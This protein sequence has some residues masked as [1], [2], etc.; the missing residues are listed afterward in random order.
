MTTYHLLQNLARPSEELVKSSSNVFLSPLDGEYTVLDKKIIDFH[1]AVLTATT[2][3]SN[4]RTLSIFAKYAEIDGGVMKVRK[5][6][7]FTFVA[8]QAESKLGNR[9]GDDQ[10]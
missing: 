10:T 2:P 7:L 6:H 4:R 1:P 3:Q 9:I 5:N 8:Y